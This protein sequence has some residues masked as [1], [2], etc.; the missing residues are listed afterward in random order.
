MCG[1]KMD[2]LEK[3]GDEKRAKIRHFCCKQSFVEVRDT[4]THRTQKKGLL[5]FEENKKSEKR[6]TR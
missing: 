2:K 5:F 1:K 4:E 3:K 6:R